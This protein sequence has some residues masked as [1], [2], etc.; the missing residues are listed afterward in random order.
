MPSN[1]HHRGVMLWK[2]LLFIQ[3]IDLQRQ[4]PSDMKLHRL[5]SQGGTAANLLPDYAYAYFRLRASTSAK[6]A[7]LH[8]KVSA[9]G[10]RSADS[11]GTTVKI[12]YFETPYKEMATN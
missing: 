5:I 6:L 4:L 8:K 12:S 11:T 3:C 7:E 2:V 10:K 1:T 9:Y